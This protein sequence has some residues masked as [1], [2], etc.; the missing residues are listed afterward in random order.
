LTCTECTAGDEGADP[1]TAAMLAEDDVEA[2]EW[3][4]SS[5][6]ARGKAQRIIR[7]TR[8]D[9]DGQIETGLEQSEVHGMQIPS[10]PLQLFVHDGGNVTRFPWSKKRMAMML[11]QWWW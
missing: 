8:A 2:E 6:G 10:C 4:T 9:S 11:A 7:I 3:L 1:E 5:V